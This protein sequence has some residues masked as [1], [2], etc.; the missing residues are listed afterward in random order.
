MPGKILIADPI[1][2][3]RIAFKMLLAKEYFDLCVTG[4]DET[5]GDTIEKQRPDVVLVSER[6]AKTTG[7]NICRMIKSDPKTCDLPVIIINNVPPHDWIS[8]ENC[9]ADDLISTE[10]DPTYLI[11]RIR[12]L[13]RRKA[14]LDASLTHLRTAELAG[15][16]ENTTS[17]FQHVKRRFNVCVLNDGSSLC[18]QIMRVLTRTKSQRIGL[19]CDTGALIHE[20]ARADIIII[21]FLDKLFRSDQS[22]VWKINS[23]IKETDKPVLV[24]FEHTNAQ[25]HAMAVRLGLSEYS[26]GAENLDRLGLRIQSMVHFTR[27][28]SSAGDILSNHV[29]ESKIDPL[30]GLYNRRYGMKYLSHLMRQPSSMT[31]PLAVMM[32]DLDNFKALNDTYGHV[33]GDQILKELGGLLKNCIRSAD[34]IMRMGGEEFLLMLPDCF[35]PTAQS[36]AKRILNKIRTAQF[37][38]DE[39]ST[40]VRVTASI[41]IAI[42]DGYEAAEK[43]I[44]RA[45]SALFQSKTHG[46]DQYNYCGT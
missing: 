37:I 36:I 14:E 26:C 30:T 10:N 4:C 21:P 9:G 28:K 39:F 24:V 25:S 20:T 11:Q 29:Q 34:M 31:K 18:D 5:I 40:Q 12:T 17:T 33:I 13:Y 43:F 16:S 38:S 27:R 7:F 44:S 8:A 6:F 45:D 23:L 32:L 22:L 15:F 2:T 41:G 42:H 19:N 35:L 1:V 46:R 3:N